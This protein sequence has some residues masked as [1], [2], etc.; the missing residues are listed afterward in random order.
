MIYVHNAQYKS[1]VVHTAVSIIDTLK[2]RILSQDQHTEKEGKLLH[3][4][5]LDSI[6]QDINAFIERRDRLLTIISSIQSSH[7]DLIRE[8]TSFDIPNII[9]IVT[10]NHD[11]E[12]FTCD[13]C[14]SYTTKHKMSLAAHKRHC[15]RKGNKI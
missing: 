1:D 6:N 7:K 12:C 14:N 10:N 4:E 5:E 8:I 13:I 3:Q 15:K 11:V 9:N 2:M